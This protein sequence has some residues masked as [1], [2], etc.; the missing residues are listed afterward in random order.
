MLWR[1]GQCAH[2][3]FAGLAEGL[4]WGRQVAHG[5]GEYP[6]FLGAHEANFLVQK[7]DFK[8]QMT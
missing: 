2:S 1:V 4:H 8:W 6:Q 3:H 7:L 5:L